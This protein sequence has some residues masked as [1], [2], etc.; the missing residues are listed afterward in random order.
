M[1]IDRLSVIIDHLP[2]T[3]THNM[4]KSIMET[5]GAVENVLLYK[6]LHGSEERSARV[7]F[8][9]DVACGKALE[10]MSGKCTVLPSTKPVVLR[11]AGAVA[12]TGPLHCWAR[13]WAT[14]P[15][16]MPFNSRD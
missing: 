4:V 10:N 9:E 15:V 12:D 8:A 7:T 11:R 2:A 16:G 6:A 1:N 14:A 5:Y 13:I 3:V